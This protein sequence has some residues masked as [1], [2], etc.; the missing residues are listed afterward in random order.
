MEERCIGE[1]PV[2]AA[3]GKPQR[4]KVLLPHFATAVLA[5][6]CG[7]RWRSLEAHRLVTQ[8]A[9]G[10]E[11]AAGA[12]AEIEYA[13]RWHT[14]DVPQQRLDVLLYIVVARALP[15][16]HGACVVVLERLRGDEGQV[17]VQQFHR[18]SGLSLDSVMGLDGRRSV[19]QF[20]G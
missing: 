2:E 15:E 17:V 20:A 19:V 1:D 10:G 8:R 13:K 5:R 7:E 11:V 14:A 4:Q 9:K 3:G 6:H 16:L 18:K 12:A